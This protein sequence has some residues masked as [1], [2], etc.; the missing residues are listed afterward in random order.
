MSDGV[1]RSWME[2]EWITYI[3]GSHF[4]FV[5]SG[6]GQQ[7][8]ARGPDLTPCLFAFVLGI[9]NDVYFF[10]GLKNNKKNV[11]VKSESDKK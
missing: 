4:S 5:F 7:I 8:M 1:F 11:F 10:M 2:W 9:K 3:L 6:R